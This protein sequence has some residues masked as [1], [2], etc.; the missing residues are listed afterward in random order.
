MKSH[1]YWFIYSILQVCHVKI[2][3]NEEKTSVEGKEL[4]KHLVQVTHM[5]RR[6]QYFGQIVIDGF[7]FDVS[8]SNIDSSCQVGRYFVLSVTNGPI[9]Y[10]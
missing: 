9:F 7:V 4:D 6:K 2:F 10:T 8:C 3:A 5:Y 1:Q